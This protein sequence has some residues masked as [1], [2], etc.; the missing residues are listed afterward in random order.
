MTELIFINLSEKDKSEN[1]IVRIYSKNKTIYADV[2]PIVKFSDG[3]WAYTSIKEGFNKFYKE[4]NGDCRTLFR[5]TCRWLGVW[6]GRLYFPDEEYYSD[7]L[8]TMF[9]IWKQLEPILQSKI[10]SYKL[11]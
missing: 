9:D 1:F 10:E 2:Y 5:V 3:S 8:Q 6:D 4:L 11:N 7:E